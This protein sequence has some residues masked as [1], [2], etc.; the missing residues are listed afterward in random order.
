MRKFYVL[1]FGAFF[2]SEC[3]GCFDTAFAQNHSDEIRVGAI[4]PVSGDYAQYGTE[5]WRGME[6]AQSNRGEK[7]RPIK[8]ILEDSGTMTGRTTVSAAEKLVS[9]NQ[10]SVLA[11]LGSDDVRPLIGLGRRGEVSILS[12]WDNSNALKAMGGFVFCN[13]FV[14]ERTAEMYAQFA[15]KTLKLKRAA[16]IGNHTPWSTAIIA[17]FTKN[18]ETSGG[19][20]VFSESFNDDMSD[21][22]AV[23]PRVL[24]QK[25]DFVFLPLSLPGGVSAAI[26]QLREG[27]FSAPIF[28]GEAFVGKTMKQ[29]GKR[30]N[31]VYVGWLPVPQK[32]LIEQ[33]KAKYEVEPCDGGIVE[34]GYSGAKAI[35]DSVD[36][37]THASVKQALADYFGPSRSSNKRYKLYL[38]RDGKLEPVH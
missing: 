11:V 29:L 10:V 5:L 21:F 31:G 38:A 36:R 16:I 35:F 18:L 1:F 24:K 22:R 32:S 19:Q 37:S 7:S 8:I 12:L 9:I 4:L 6:L 34:I 3:L 27:G 17:A 26:R 15:R 25:P 23:V 2:L 33:Y 14:L 13:G 30:G 20:I 28:A